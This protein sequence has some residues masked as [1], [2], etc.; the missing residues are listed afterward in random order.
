MFLG[1]STL[2]W[3]FI[4]CLIAGLIVSFV[5]LRRICEELNRVLPPAENVTLYPPWPRSLGQA[6][7][8]TNLFAHS[9]VLLDQH[10]QHYP[11]SSLRKVYGIAALSM[12]PSVIGVMAMTR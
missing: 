4:A 10:R 7:W 1:E 2:A 8:R 11:S 3:P 12:L 6:I 9:L 5:S